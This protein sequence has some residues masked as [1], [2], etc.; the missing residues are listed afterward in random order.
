MIKRVVVFY[1]FIL[2]VLKL[3]AQNDD[4][5]HMISGVEISAGKISAFSA[6][7][8]V[9]KID[10]TTLAIRQGISIATLLSEQSPVFLRSYGP[11][12]ISTLSVRGTNASQSGV[13]WNG[14]NLSQPNM[15]MTDLSRISTFEFSDLSL[16]SGGASALLGSG[17]IG[18][19]LHLAN[20]LKFSTPVHASI[21]TS[22]SSYGNIEGA[23]KLSAGNSRLAYNGSL[24]VNW[25]KNNFRYTDLAGN[26]KKL[27]HALS[28]SISSIHQAEYIIN[29]NQRLSAGFWFQSTD[30][31]IPPTMTMS[32]SDQQQLDQ[33][34]RSSLQWSY[35]G[36]NQLFIIRTAFIDE[37]EH[38]QSK[39]ELIDAFY[40]LNTFQTEFEYKR[41][42]G[43]HLTLGSGIS[44]RVTLADVTYYSMNECL[45]EGSV[46]LA[47]AYF[48]SKTG[49]KSVLNLRQDFTNGYSIP[50][51]PSLSAEIPVWKRMSASL[52]VSRNFR[53]P[54]M[55]DRFWIP[56]GNPDLKP[57]NSWN[58][59]AGIAYQMY[60]GE[61]IQSRIS[62]NVYNLIIDN[63]IQWV[64]VNAGIW[65]PMNVQKVWSRGIELVSKTDVKMAGFIGYFKFGYNYTPSTYR[66][67]SQEDDNLLN[68]QL[69]Y[70][71][72]HKLNET[73]Y[74]AKNQYYTMFSYTF[75]GKRYV[76]SDNSKSLPSFAVL[77]LFAGTT[78]KTENLN[79]RIQAEIRNI[80]NTTYQSV[81]YYP[82]PGRSFSINLIISNNIKKQ[83]R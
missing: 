7:M 29:R 19:S 59:E 52:G 33:A 14:I 16:Q 15:G 61:S 22:G 66:E 67:T 8:K 57:E 42:L 27:E 28:E 64:P 50:F 82:E 12:G 74:I 36:K 9:E 5:I 18:G 4:T 13:F 6:G 30:R 48:H 56:G 11:G 38:F 60:T 20:A 47:L 32:K 83:L 54:T 69:I 75:T 76:Q 17:V 63:L 44:S 24:S 58:L 2:L 45:Q 41:N 10:S 31:Q 21:L 71:P 26:S 62:M 51:C 34:I 53:V 25:D 49:I 23:F 78:L 77:D 68:K 37:K 79:F 40:H 55:N 3:P 1:V 72:L 65:S 80:I 81:L 35:S 46:W 39:T 43:K 70:I 73:F